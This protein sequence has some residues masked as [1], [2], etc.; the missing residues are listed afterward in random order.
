M[1]KKQSIID[2]FKKGLDL[3]ESI[4]QSW[5][6]FNGSIYIWNNYLPV[7]RNPGTDEKLLESILGLL[8]EFFDKMKNSFREL[9]KK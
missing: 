8:K 7:F 2:Y 4:N 1:A 5:L 3:A 9:E 6:I